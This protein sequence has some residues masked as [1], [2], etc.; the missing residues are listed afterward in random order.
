MRSYTNYLLFED[1]LDSLDDGA[2]TIIQGVKKLLTPAVLI[3]E[4]N[5]NTL[6][7]TLTVTNFELE[8]RTELAT[9]DPLSRTRIEEL[10]SEGK[11]VIEIRELPTCISKGG[12]CQEC[13]HASRPW[14]NIPSVGTTITLD[15]PQ[16]HQT[17]LIIG[18]NNS[19]SFSLSVEVE[20][21]DFIE[22]I[23]DGERVS[24]D[25]YEVSG[26]QITFLFTPGLESIYVV[27][28]YLKS[29]DSL[30]N[31]MAKSYSGGLLGL[32]PLSS[33]KTYLR[34]SLYASMF[35]EMFIKVMIRELDKFD[36][37][38]TNMDYIDRIHEPLEKALYVLYLYILNHQLQ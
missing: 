2:P 4:N 5:C 26:N 37:P 11:Y 21:Y 9:G 18:N 31:Y 12:I 35:S 10:L 7:G 17:D 23:H 29:S 22:V 8:G 32:K 27:H 28:F 30:L 38:S 15:I 1:V 25:S 3:V 13:F 36:I 33:F 16:I 34:P 6:L 24:S 19:T 14:D 20:D